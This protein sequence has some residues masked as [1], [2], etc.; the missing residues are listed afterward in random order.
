MSGE[1][2][3]QALTGR[4]A[5]GPSP[6]FITVDHGTEFLTPNECVPNV[7]FNRPPK[8]HSALLKNRLGR[9]ANV[10]VPENSLFAWLRSGEAYRTTSIS[11]RRDKP[12]WYL[13]SFMSVPIKPGVT[14]KQP[15]STHFYVHC[16]LSTGKCLKDTPNV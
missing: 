5:K 6:R 13:V 11:S 4:G 10:N 7:R 16:H 1:T 12:S 8:R 2:V 15:A 9:G 3:N 14:V